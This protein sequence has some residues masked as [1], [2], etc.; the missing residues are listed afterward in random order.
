MN[1]MVDS[2]VVEMHFDNSDFMD[3][4]EETIEALERLNDQISSINAAQGL[5]N[6]TAGADIGLS[7]VEDSLGNIESRFSILG[8]VGMTIVQRLT[9]AAIDGIQKV[10]SLLG[11]AFRQAKTGGFVRASNIE[12]AKFLLEGLGADV[13]AVFARVDKAVTGTAYGIDEAARAASSFY[14]SGIT[15]LDKLQN[16]LRAV[17]GV[18]AMTGS[19]FAS[20][21]DIFTT[22]AGQGKVMT[23]QLR[24]MEGRGLNAAATMRDFI[25]KVIENGDQFNESIR[26]NV[27]ELTGGTK[28]SEE[29]VREFVNKGKIDFELFSEAMDNAFGK[30]AQEANKTFSGSLAN[31]KTSLSRLGEAFYTP[32][33]KAAIPVFNRLRETFSGLTNELKK[34][35]AARNIDKLVDS[36]KKGSK[37]TLANLRQFDSYLFDKE[38]SSRSTSR[39]IWGYLLEVKKGSIEASEAIKKSVEDI[40]DEILHSEAA[41]EKWVEEGKLDADLFAA[42]MEH[43]TQEFKKQSNVS[44]MVSAFGSSMQKLGNSIASLIKKF[45]E[46]EVISNSAEAIYNSFRILK[47]IFGAVGEAFKEVFTG[48]AIKSLES[49]TRSLADNTKKAADWLLAWQNIAPFKNVMIGIFSGF[50][51]AINIFKGVIGV[52]KSAAMAVFGLTGK[53]GG[54]SEGFKNLMQGLDKKTGTIG[55]FEKLSKLLDELGKLADKVF[56]KFTNGIGIVIKT[57]ADGIG[58]I[59]S[60]DKALA[61]TGLLFAALF[62]QKTIRKL[63]SWKNRFSKEMREFLRFFDLSSLEEGG[64]FLTNQINDVLASTTRCLKQM[65]LKV[66]ADI[67]QKIAISVLALAIAL[68]LLETVDATKLQGSL[69]AIT[70]LMGEMTLVMA[71]MINLLNKSAF[72]DTIKGIY[73]LGSV[74]NALIK[75]G[76]AMILMAVALKMISELDPNELAKGLI[77]LTI[78][79]GAVLGFLLLLDHYQ[80]AAFDGAAAAIVLAV[81]TSLLIMAKAVEIISRLKVEKLAKGL[82]GMVILLGSVFGFLAGL[83]KLEVTMGPGMVAAGIGMIAIAAAI[84]ILVPALER[85]GSLPLDQLANGLEAIIAALISMAIASDMASAEGGAGI[86]MMAVAVSSLVTSLQRIAEMSIGDIAKG[87]VTI[88]LGL[89]LLVATAWGLSLIEAPLIAVA[90]AMLMLSGSVAI[91][92]AGLVLIG[93]GFTSISAGIL[94]FS[95]VTATSLR[96]FLDTIKAIIQGLLLMVPEIAAALAKGFIAFLETIA[97]LAPRFTEAVSTII[98][99]LLK[100]IED[101]FPKIVNAG[102]KLIL[103]FLE[104]MSEAIPRITNKAVD[105]ITGFIDALS[106]RMPD[107]VDSG[108]NFIISFINGLAEGI[109]KHKRDFATAIENLCTAGLEAFLAFFG[110]ASPS[111]VMEQHGANLVEGLKQGIQNAGDIGGLLISAVSSGLDKIK[112][113]IS[114]YTGKGRDLIS[115]LGQGI[116]E[117]ASDVKDKIVDAVSKAK[118]HVATSSIVSKFKSA[119]K[120]LSE[121]VANGIRNGLS[122]VISAVGAIASKALSNF[123]SKLGVNS[124][125]KVFMREAVCI[126]EGVALGIDKGSRFVTKAVDRMAEGA[127]SAMN[128]AVS[129]SYDI[130]GSDDNFNPTI[131]PILDLSQVRKES[132]GLNSMFGTETVSLAS[133]FN[134]ND[135][136]NI[137]NGNLMNQLLTKMDRILNTDTRKPANITNTFTVNGNDNPEEFVNTFIRTLDREMQMRAV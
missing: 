29:A 122:S 61:T 133:S 35:D 14:A 77:G 88:A 97:E 130:L 127:V 87:F 89:G 56:K 3:K 65:T 112:S 85:I 23:M 62:S 91:L 106:Q 37:I 109:R 9:N 101:N 71:A 16:S 117:K 51:A 72:T 47:T 68:K 53:V 105:I 26:K 86:L 90:G 70:V 125:S 25:N 120:N 57:I 110:I 104:G 73:A 22:V 33:M 18:A 124:P 13:E 12:Q 45:N 36:V 78:M 38:N 81:A 55:I 6:L 135:I 114:K 116:K 5:S 42:A 52:L 49:F 17:A 44:S 21:A 113:T 121:G 30:H 67:V 24:M 94:S 102:I 92:G 123:K 48:S 99:S 100:A 128:D 131:T 7:N 50:S 132:A 93:L 59:D 119:G 108:I 11:A 126:P 84:N 63:L 4:I 75:I 96:M 54:L 20:I 66:N 2:R 39:G 8:I 40:P 32:A 79:L 103:N 134:Q 83:S 46:S 98:D 136:Q 58:S 27:Q 111:K 107:I 31:L 76:I 137:Q 129:K 43:L 74:T 115:G 82:G 41:F 19:D 69:E 60:M 1:G 15:D 64:K 118:D 80:E 95:T 28:V 10:S 34:S